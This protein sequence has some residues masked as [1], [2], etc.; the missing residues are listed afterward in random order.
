MG[1]THGD[2]G[3]HRPAQ[4]TFGAETGWLQALSFHRHT[5]PEPL[6]GTGTMGAGEIRLETCPYR[7]DK[8]R[9]QTCDPGAALEKQTDGGF[10][11]RCPTQARVMVIKEG[12]LEEVAAE[13]WD[14]IGRVAREKAEGPMACCAFGNHTQPRSHLFQLLGFC[15]G[16]ALSQNDLP[17]WAPE[18][19]G[20]VS[21]FT[22]Q[23]RRAL[24]HPSFPPS[25]PPFIL[26]S[27][28]LSGVILHHDTLT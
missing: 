24:L 13:V 12:F 2:P 22:S 18:C 8:W 3:H 7:A 17:M 21:S 25:T 4:K 15:I 10:Q 16:C 23:L 1:R 6:V 11:R 28:H 27:W 19:S 26:S 14:G 5:L 20:S 9:R